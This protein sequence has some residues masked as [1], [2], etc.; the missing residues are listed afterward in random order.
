[1]HQR[2]SQIVVLMSILG[3]FTGVPAVP[4]AT[5]T[6]LSSGIENPWLDRTVDPCDDFYRFS[7]GNWM[8][9]HPLPPDRGYFDRASELQEH[10]DAILREILEKASAG[11]AARSP[12]SRKI[13]DLYASC[14]DQK[15]LEAR[16]ASPLRSELDGISRMASKRDLA[17]AVGRLHLLGAG[18][19]AT[20]VAGGLLFDFGP[21]TDLTN[22]MSVIAGIGESGLGLPH[23]D[24]Y[25]KRDAESRKTV[26]RY[27]GHLTKIFELLGDDPRRAARQS[28]AVLRVETGLARAMEDR[29]SKRDPG[30]MVRRMS[31]QELKA[32]AP[33]FDWKRYFETLGAPAFEVIE[34]AS[35]GFFRNLESQ[36]KTHPLEDWKSYLRWRLGSSCSPFLTPDFADP[37]ASFYAE[38]L[39]GA[40]GNRPRWQRCVDLVRDQ[41]GDALGESYVAATFDSRVKQQVNAMAGAI[42]EALA[43]DI[44]DLRWMSEPTK[45]QALLKLSAVTHRIGFPERWRDDG[46][47]DIVRDDLFGNVVRCRR[48]EMARQLRKIGGPVDRGEWWMSPSLV[49]G[50]YDYQTNVMDLAA[51]ILQFPFYVEGRDEAVNFGAMGSIIGHELTHG[52]DDQGR[53]FD[54]TGALRDGWGKSDAAE[55]KKRAECF[56]GQYSS[57]IAVDDVHLDGAAGL[58]ESIADNGGLHIAYMALMARLSASAPAPGDGFTPAQRFFLGYAQAYCEN[59]SE[60]AARLFA[61]TGAHTLAKIRVNGAVSNLPEFG[62]AFRCKAGSLMLRSSPC[63]IW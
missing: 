43:K 50:S 28:E 6:D 48:N 38:V 8:K 37:T 36:L 54:A 49:N 60:Q 23:R 41:M 3:A 5:E 17:E 40:R 59:V 33:S 52:F 2:L 22:P 32:S 42:E 29:S 1:M 11:E 21:T 34:V 46:S 63:R 26:T 35:P 44:R 10:N 27:R 12:A 56:V 30:Q 25:L 45:E 19:P 9:S 4:G 47:I 57:F 31:L 61:L 18:Q 14:M 53:Q 58:G 15:A 24:Y 20:P 39:G 16:G 62:K 55:F 51:G 7:C 13:G